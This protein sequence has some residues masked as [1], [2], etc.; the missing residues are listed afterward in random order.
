MRTAFWPPGYR[1]RLSSDFPLPLNYIYI[2]FFESGEKFSFD[3]I[4]SLGGV[5]AT[6][7][8]HVKHV[9]IFTSL[10]YPGGMKSQ[11]YFQVNETW[12]IFQLLLGSFLW[13][14][15]HYLH[16]FKQNMTTTPKYHLHPL[17]PAS[18]RA[19]HQAPSKSL[20][21]R[22]AESLF[23]VNYCQHGTSPCWVLSFSIFPQSLPLKCSYYHLVFFQGPKSYCSQRRE[24]NRIHDSI[25]IIALA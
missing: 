15:S 19:V 6:L 21:L 2:V 12:L 23:L 13:L 11:M 9:Q 24:E 8:I 16:W 20:L 4:S 14:S 25:V 17:F 10:T 7:V 3:M 1:S 22:F 18:S 5:W